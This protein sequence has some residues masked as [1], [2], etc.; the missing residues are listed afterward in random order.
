[1]ITEVYSGYGDGYSGVCA[2]HASNYRRHG[3]IE[4]VRVGLRWQLD[5]RM[6]RFIE[7]HSREAADLVLRMPNVDVVELDAM[8][9]ELEVARRWLAQTP[10]SLP[11]W[12]PPDDALDRFRAIGNRCYWVRWMVQVPYMT[13][14]EAERWCEEVSGA[15]YR[16]MEFPEPYAT[17][18]EVPERQARRMLRRADLKQEKFRKRHPEF[19]RR[20]SD[21]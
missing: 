20:P 1:M 15:K 9:S 19:F 5:A 7:G 18:H 13:A 6:L 2:W 4:A 10:E 8:E 17:P 11:G 3:R 21:P 14:D 16:S 12:T